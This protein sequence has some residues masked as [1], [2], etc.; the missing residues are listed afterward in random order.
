[1]KESNAPYQVFLQKKIFTLNQGDG[2][3]NYV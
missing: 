2:I 1:M 3:P